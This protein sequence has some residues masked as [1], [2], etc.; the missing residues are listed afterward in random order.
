MF[1]NAFEE[2]IPYDTLH[3]RKFLDLDTFAKLTG[4]CTEDLLQLNPSLRRNAVPE[5]PRT[6]ILKV[7]LASKSELAKYRITILDSASKAGRKEIEMMAKNEAG[8]TTGRELL[9]YFVK[10]GDALSTI[11]QRYRV[12]VD[13]LR[14]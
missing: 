1:E 2:V 13:D 5:S 3:I 12:R 10:N 14:K 11:A 4:T 9:V 7:P 6:F 8:N